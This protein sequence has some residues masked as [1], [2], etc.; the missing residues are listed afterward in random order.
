MTDVIDT[1]CVDLSMTGTGD[2]NNNGSTN[3][4]D[5]LRK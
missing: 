5:G 4:D 1:C 2:N 3:I